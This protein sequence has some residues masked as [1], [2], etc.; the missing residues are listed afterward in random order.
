MKFMEKKSV[1][2]QMISCLS[3]L[4]C[5]CSLTNFKESL[6]ISSKPT[7][8]D[9]S[10]RFKASSLY[11]PLVYKRLGESLVLNDI[12]IDSEKPILL[13]TGPNMGGKST[14]LRACGISILLAQIGSFVPCESLELSIFHKIFS[15]IGA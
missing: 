11:H 5:L 3:E 13:I 4:D 12:T 14:L 15:R 2:L 8:C 6:P 7:F 1:W 10:R 9:G